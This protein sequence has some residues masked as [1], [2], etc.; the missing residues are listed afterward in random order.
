MLANLLLLLLVVPGAGN[1]LLP[2][3]SL[4]LCISFFLSLCW[5]AFVSVSPFGTELDFCHVR[6]WIEQAWGVYEIL[7]M[8][9]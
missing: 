6:G 1:S 5:D 7:R 4:S 3:L 9:A 8:V 2:S